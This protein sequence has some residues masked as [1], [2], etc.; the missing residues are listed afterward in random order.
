MIMSK[1]EEVKLNQEEIKL[2]YLPDGDEF[3]SGGTIHYK[4]I[5]MKGPLS[6]MQDVQVYWRF[7]DPCSSSQVCLEGAGV[8]KEPVLLLRRKGRKGQ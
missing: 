7:L 1:T 5:P 6:K 4:D 8:W 2:G 3:V